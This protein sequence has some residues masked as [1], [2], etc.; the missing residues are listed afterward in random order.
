MEVWELTPHIGSRTFTSLI[1][2]DLSRLGRLIEQHLD[3]FLELHDDEQ[4]REGVTLTIRL[5]D[6]SQEEYEEITHE[7]C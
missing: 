4:L 5:I 7:T 3:S 6:L 1:E 2:K